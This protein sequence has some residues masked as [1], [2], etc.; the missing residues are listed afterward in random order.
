[1]KISAYVPFFNNSQTIL[2]ALESLREQTIPPD[3]IF[4]LDDG[5]TDGGSELVEDHGFRCL[6]QHSNQGRGAVRQRAMLEASGELVVSCDATNV[7]PPHFIES[8]L[9]WFDDPTVAA[10]YGWIQDPHPKGAVG[11]WRARHLFKAG[12][13]MTIRHK[14]PLIT[15]GTILRRSAALDVGNFNPAFRHSEDGELGERLLAAGWDTIFDP[16][17]P[18]ICNVQNTL[19]EALERYWRWYVGVADRVSLLGYLRNVVYSVKCTAMIDLAH[20]DIPVALISLLCPHLQFI[21]SHLRNL[22]K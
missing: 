22:D 20:G 18:V 7:L 13:P 21:M 10:V 1:M 15:Y 19:L 11:R 4:A 2:P 17:V 16:R 6:S 12:H 9:P 3:E 14:S 8:L 5:S